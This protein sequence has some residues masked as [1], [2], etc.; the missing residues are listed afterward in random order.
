MRACWSCAASAE[1]DVCSACGKLQPPRTNDYFAYLGIPRAYHLDVE[2]LGEIMRERSRTLHPDRYARAEPRER[3]LS[4]Q[5]TTL[6]NDAVRT[7]R[8][9]QR[10][11]EY[12][13]SLYG[14]KAGSNDRPGAKLEPTFL[15][16]MMET[17][18][19][20][21][22]ARAKSDAASLAKIVAAA[23]V[24]QASLQTQADA[25]FTVWEKNS[26]E[27]K[28]LEQIVGILDKMR[29]FEQI[30]AEAEGRTTH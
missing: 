10:R 17:R 21:A 13:L 16:E 28:P 3:S 29:Y 20:L 25:K 6:L 30:L 2:K 23:K 7:L 18:E 27:K 24:K 26:A 9:P 1:G 11:A 8:D 15:M 22:E 19:A 14:L 12:V 4:M 5:H